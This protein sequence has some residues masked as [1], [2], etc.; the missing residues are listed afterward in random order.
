MRNFSKHFVSFNLNTV[1]H[2]LIILL[3]SSLM[4]LN[5]LKYYIPINESIV[6]WGDPFTYEMSYYEL[7]NKINNGEIYNTIRYIFGT[8]WY[9]LQKILITFFSP[10]ITNE[11][12]SL[13]VINFFTYGVASIL[14]YILLIELNCKKELS[15]FL[16]ILIWIYPINY[17][18]S[19]YSSLPMMGLDSTFLGSLYCLIFSYLTFL[20][21]PSSFKY[22]LSFSVFLCASF[23]GRGNSITVIGV[24]CFL[25]TISF[26]YQIIKNKDYKILKHFII[27]LIFFLTTAIL[28]YSL[29]L[30]HILNYY[31]VFRG[32]FTNDLSL[33]LPYLKHIPGIFF[34]YPSQSEINLMQSTDYRLLSISLICHLINF[35][36]YFFQKS[37]KNKFI[38][39]IIL[40]GIFIFYFT[41]FTNL[42]MWMNPHINIYNAQLIWA[43]MRI[44]F[45]LVISMLLFNL[46]LNLKK[47]YINILSIFLVII[48]FNIS[49]IS[50]KSHKTQIFKNKIDSNPQKIKSIETFIKKNSKDGKSIVLW[51]GPYL[52]PRIINY[53]SIKKNSK[54]ISYFRDKYADDIWNQSDKSPEFIKKVAYEIKSIFHNVDLLI[55]NENSKNYIGGYAYYRYKNFITDEIKNGKLDDFEIIAKI[56]SS[57]GNLLMFKRKNQKNKNFYYSINENDDYK[58]IYEKIENIF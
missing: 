17:N 58:I 35:F 1:F 27:P 48:I 21:K 18:F 31:S 40:T 26:L 14:F 41:F 43:P 25:P 57:R 39:L 30:K 8:N 22:Q 45:I 13:C 4:Y 36:S 32:F 5:L 49:N 24:V 11:P 29:Q 28:F 10:L 46:I 6:P 16:S 54:P 33:T 15:R 7:L 55:I 20:K 34:I 56:K 37:L 50:Y 52:N 42:L 38:K 44:G 9:W 19:E 51:Y 2:C 12:Y 3:F 47:K 53:Y 23:I